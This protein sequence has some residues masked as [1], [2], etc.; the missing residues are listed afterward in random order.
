M[1]HDVY[2]APTLSLIAEFV[3][4]KKSIVCPKNAYLMIPALINS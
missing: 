2:E 1:L 4:L 3:V